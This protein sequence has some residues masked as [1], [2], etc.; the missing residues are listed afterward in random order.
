MSEFMFKNL[1]V[2]LMPAEGEAVKEQCASGPACGLNCS[3]VPSVAACTL[4]CSNVPSIPACTLNCSNVPSAP[5][6]TLNCSQAYSV[7]LYPWWTC[8]CTS[9]VTYVICGGFSNDQLNPRNATV[10]PATELAALKEQL[11][12]VGSAIQAAEQ[13][14]T[15]A[16]RPRTV[17]EIDQ[18]KSRLLEAVAELD[19]QR[20]QMEGGGPAEG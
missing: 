3:N 19:D 6:C 13:R 4:N 12:Q 14:I 5:A 20:A 10:D 17:E 9:P 16:G 8:N 15:P 18:V 1:S 7:D 11:R 2:K